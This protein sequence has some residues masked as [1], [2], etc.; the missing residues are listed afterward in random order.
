MEE[1][2][3]NF[4]KIVD[5]IKTK[6]DNL[7]KNIRLFWLEEMIEAKSSPLLELPK[8]LMHKYKK[9]VGSKVQRINDAVL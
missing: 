1:A 5:C 8:L 4:K 3:R 6:F 7:V 2:E 9:T